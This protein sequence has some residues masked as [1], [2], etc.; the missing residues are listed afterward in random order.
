MRRAGLG[1]LC[2]V[3]A[4]CSG[5]A[6]RT[7]PARPGAAVPPPSTLAAKRALF[8]QAHGLAG[9]QH[10]AEAIPALEALC[11]VYP[12]M[13]DYC[14]ND[15]A[16]SR[17]HTGDS[18]A[19]ET[20]WAR[21]IANHPQSLFTPRAELERGRLRLAAGDAPTARPLLE[22][23]RAGEDDEVAT[24]ALL[25]LAE[26]EL[27]AGNV[28]MAVADLTAA[29]TRAPGSAAGR[30]ARQR[31]DAL[32][33]Q[34]PSL[35]PQGDALVDEVRLL[36]RERDF[37]AARATADRAMASAPAYR[38]EL[39]RL[40]AD[41]ELGGGQ[42]DE[43]L[44][45]LKEIV[46]EYPDTDAAGDALFRYGTLLWNRDRDAEAEQAFLELQRRYP[47][48]GKRAD[49][50]YALARI[51]QGDG[52][53][54]EA[55]RDYEQLADAYPGTALA[56]EARWRIGWIRYQQGRFADAA[57]AFA[58]AAANAEP[59]QAA[60]A[61]YWRARALERVG[62]RAAAERVYETLL[63]ES[64]ASY[65]ARLAAQRLGRAEARAPTPSAPAATVIG[66]PP[67][68]S[69]P[70]HWIRA[71]ELQAMDAR[72]MARAELH[73]FER[74]HAD[75][76]T[77]LAPMV[78]AYQAVDGYREAIRLGSARGLTDAQI[79]FPLAFWPQVTRNTRGTDIDP[80]FVLALIRQ[81][82]M[83]DPS[84]RSPADARGL[85][86]L[87]PS[88][89]DRVARRTGQPSPA[90]KLY[91]PETNVTL[92]TA[93]LHELLQ[94]YGGDPYKT[95][96]AYNGGEAAVAKWQARFGNLEPDE[97]VESITYRETRDYVK[98]VMGNYRRY[99]IEYGGR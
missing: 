57:T 53:T 14:L 61:E 10:Y 54:E 91:D 20:L 11:P 32:R 7:A 80:L 81:E 96:A 13:E 76:P 31:L 84:A 3:V 26:L 87:L 35:A 93:H 48:H 69:N 71:G 64:P 46:R 40:R 19:A 75:D 16:L 15:L 83:F 97:F 39:L 25:E 77:A 49:A 45:T 82:S 50:L 37:S 1:W 6:A 90:G 73:A 52:R 33:S 67:I 47:G 4:A 28:Q 44:A 22:A 62:D 27:A 94:S 29:R 95:L 68:G 92:G 2:V 42:T 36:L 78:S 70:Y 86:Q 8:V 98:R 74:A 5:A 23:A 9:A 59:G 21:L 12:E 79:F 66:A 43:G 63:S 41:A 34:D 55:V 99:Q 56:R 24:R 72:P 85:M 18:A 30:A 65:Y 60:D 89:A 17:A 38:A 88:T 51:A 58:H